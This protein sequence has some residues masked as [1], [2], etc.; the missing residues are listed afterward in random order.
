MI[1]YPAIGKHGEHVEGV[2][3]MCMSICNTEEYKVRA[4]QV[5]KVIKDFM[6]DFEPIHVNGNY[7][8]L[9]KEPEIFVAFDLV[10]D[11]GSCLR[12]EHKDEKQLRRT[13]S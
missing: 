4:N 1:G 12:K 13:N 5:A 8:D 10:H 9:D 11:N 3:T 2:E 6:I 7:I